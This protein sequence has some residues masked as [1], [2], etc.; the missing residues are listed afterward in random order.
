MVA[1]WEDVYLHGLG[2]A[3]GRLLDGDLCGLVVV[4]LLLLVGGGVGFGGERYAHDLSCFLA[5]FGG[6]GKVTHF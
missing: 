4:G 3:L 6:L 5:R 2:G 1:A